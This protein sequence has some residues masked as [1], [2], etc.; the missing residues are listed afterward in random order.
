VIRR[1]L[2]IILFVFCILLGAGVFLMEKDWVDFSMLDAYKGA[3]ASVILD[4]EGREFARFELDKRDSISFNKIPPMLVKAFLAAEDHDFFTH[5]GISFRGIIRSAL[6]NM[7]H[8]RKVQGASTITQQLARGMFLSYERTWLR[9]IQEIFVALQLERQLSKEQIFELY[10]NNIY[11]GRGIYGVEAAC[12]RFWDKPLSQL[13]IDQAATLAAVAKSAALFS[14][15]NAPH[16]TQIR[17]NIILNSMYKLSYIAQEE[18][19]AACKIVVQTKDYATGNPIRLYIQE[20]IRMWAENTFGKDVLYHK[21]LK[22]RATINKSLQEH[23]ERVF[24]QSLAAMRKTMGP[25]INGG[26]ISL[27]PVTG[28][29]KVL[30]GGCDFR[31]SQFNRA[32]QARRQI[33]SSFKP[34]FYALAIKAGIEMDTVF[35]DEP[36]EMQQPNGSVWQPQN[37]NHEFEGTMTLARALT[38]SNNIIA[39]KLFLKIG[40]QYIIPWAKQFGIINKLTPY[41][42]AALGTAE[43]TVEENAAAFN[44]FA[45]NGTYV[46]PYLIEWVKDETGAKIWE[47]EEKAHRVMDSRLCSKMVNVLSLRMYRAQRFSPDG[48]INAESIGK[49]GSTNGA[50]T[51]WFVGATP[52][53]TTALYVGRDD[54][55]PMGAQ[56]F[57]TQTTLPLWINFYRSFKSTKKHFYRDPSLHE[58]AVNW[59]TGETTDDL[60]DPD[61]VVLLK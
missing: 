27:E 38:F 7:Y 48:W 18:Y 49:T 37:W 60:S 6:V 21:G 34:I 41:P 35:V 30:I 45:N 40:P 14:P 42:S 43:L 33:G 19:A 23:A 24:A 26:L 3:K 9:K 57:A 58:V 28:Q 56:L 2:I 5:P 32:L 54:N 10:L 44:V 53:L 16:N 59:L 29:I 11:F 25:E 22:I 17:R 47:Y 39:I 4:D 12:R 1:L 50:S 8:Q 61:T 20:W 15:L 36:F 31:Q 46:K 13:T 55:K 52:S 51:T